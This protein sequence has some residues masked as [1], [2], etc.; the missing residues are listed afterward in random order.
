[1]RI[2]MITELQ[3][4]V[5]DNGLVDFEA[6]YRESLAQAR[7]ADEAGFHTIW[8]TEHHF[9]PTF[10]VAPGSDQF[11]AAVAAQTNSIRVGTGVVVLPYHHPIHVAER[12]AMLDLIS[13]GRLE[14]GTGRGGPYEVTGHSIDPRDTRSMWEESLA[15][16]EAIWSSYPDEFSWEGEHW[17]IPPRVVVP[18]PVQKP[19]R[20]W[21]ACAQPA[22]FSVAAD[23][24]MGVL[25]FVP[26]PPGVTAPLIEQYR[27]RI[28]GYPGPLERRNENWASMTFG[29]CGEDGPAAR[30]LVSRS[31]KVFFGPDRPYN[32]AAA[33]ITKSLIEEWDGEIPDD[34][35]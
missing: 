26:S 33:A 18:Q 25:A 1:M 20:R 10:S 5:S 14:F 3:R 2:S 30:E 21:L 35:K 31:L 7:L 24:G 19:I 34:L 4:S 29:V 13:E 9:L 15:C 27:E 11:L 6:T 8:I 32:A 22:S 12:M 28:A 17:Q 16:I 23:H